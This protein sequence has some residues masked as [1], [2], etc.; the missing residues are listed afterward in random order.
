[1]HYFECVEKIRN[2]SYIRVNELG[3]NPQYLGRGGL[4][5]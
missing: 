3:V 2:I 1:M 5:T 4:D